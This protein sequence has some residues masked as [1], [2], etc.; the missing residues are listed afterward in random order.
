MVGTLNNLYQTPGEDEAAEFDLLASLKEALATI[1]AN[2][3]GIN[4]ADPMGI[5]YNFV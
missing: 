4:A 1:P 3:A 5:S 2:L